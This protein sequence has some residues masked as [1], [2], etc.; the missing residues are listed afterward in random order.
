MPIDAVTV[1]SLSCGR[2]ISKELD[3][4]Q[5][6]GWCEGSPYAVEEIVLDEDDPEICIPC[7]DADALVAD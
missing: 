2:H 7:L 1:G 3:S 4:H 6:E 5:A